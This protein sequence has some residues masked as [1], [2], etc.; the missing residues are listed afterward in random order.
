MRK[1]IGILVVCVLASAAAAAAG[2]Q[3]V[4]APLNVPAQVKPVLA[5][6]ESSAASNDVAALHDYLL[7]LKAEREALAIEETI[8]KQ[9]LPAQTGSES[10][11]MALMRRRMADLINKLNSMNGKKGGESTGPALLPLPGLTEKGKQS[12][13]SKQKLG[14]V[15]TG[16]IK[17]NPQEIAEVGLPADPRALAN[18]LF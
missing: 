2:R 13:P 3:D 10:Q 12:D 15:D 7:K 8:G 17:A 18:V 6:E 5:V 16:I 4:P 1:L 11:D 14:G 9:L